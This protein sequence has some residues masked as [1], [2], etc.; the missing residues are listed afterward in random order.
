MQQTISRF[1][2]PLED[3]VTTHSTVGVEG[4]A[5]V[6]VL[7]APRSF[8]SVVSS[9]LGQHPQLYG[10]PELE[11]FESA[12][13]AQWWE[14]N[15]QSTGPRS[16][17]MLRAVAELVF[18]EQTE[19]TIRLARGWLWRRS[20]LSTGYLF[21]MLAR[22]V[23]PRVPVDKSTTYV[24][25]VRGMYR[26]FQMFP[27]ARFIHLVRHPRGHAES[28][29]KLLKYVQQQGPPLPPNHWLFRLAGDTWRGGAGADGPRAEAPGAD[30][31]LD[32]QNSWYALNSNVCRFLNAVPADQ[33][34][35]IRGED[36]LTDPDGHIREL[37][38]WLGID[39]GAE[40][41]EKTKHPEESPY[42]RIGPDGARFG[43]DV[44][45]LEDPVLRL[46]PAKPQSLEGPLSWRPDGTQ[47][48]PKVKQLAREFGYE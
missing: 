18:G 8:S 32:P 1:A 14:L 28:V 43:N 47:L 36:F 35:R 22:K 4:V 21:E 12:T 20:H 26:S 39:D 27:N 37:C 7:A 13:V 46:A 11:L 44:F 24:W 38:R 29:L 31:V 41:V 17:G 34:R 3:R 15:A 23:W 16:H 48:R 5:P 40:A 2:E 45:F 25:R 42:A 30:P 6:F 19:A 10:L 9:M 33:Q